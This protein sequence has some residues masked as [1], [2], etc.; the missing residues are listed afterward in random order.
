VLHPV[1][2]T[3]NQT[4]TQ[5]IVKSQIVKKW[6]ICRLVQ[7]M[8]NYRD[9]VR[10][11]LKTLKGAKPSTASPDSSKPAESESP[12]PAG[13]LEKGARGAPEKKVKGAKKEGAASELPLTDE[14][15]LLDDILDLEEGEGGNNGDEIDDLDAEAEALL[16][17][18]NE[19]SEEKN[20]SADKT[21]PGSKKKDS[22]EFFHNNI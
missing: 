18:D 16:A 10:E 5:K 15:D 7:I 9:D 17:S 19:E 11:M 21:K 1:F 6:A 14:E 8:S 4:N 3:Q 12:E 2:L 22:C 20:K 13:E